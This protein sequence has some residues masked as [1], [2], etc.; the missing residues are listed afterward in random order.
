VLELNPEA[1]AT[2]A[3]IAHRA[4]HKDPA[5]RFRSARQMAQALRLWL[6]EQPP[7][8]DGV[9]NE[10]RRMRWDR[11]A[12]GAVV[13]GGVG[14]V[15]GLFWHGPEQKDLQ[16]AEAAASSP[17]VAAAASAAV[18]PETPASAAVA[19]AAASAVDTVVAA[20]AE[21][22][23]SA[24]SAVAKPAKAVA[25]KP[26]AEPKPITVA[27]APLANGVLQLAI[28]PWGNVEVDGAPAGITPPLNRLSLPEGAHTVTVRNADFPPFTTTVKITADQ[29]VTLR[30]RFGS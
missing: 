29:P 10:R 14:L 20:A 3:A 11:V 28:A 8:T 5:E 16:A 27:A 24:A 13:V 21:P 23:A 4:L 7:G 2:L 17:V 22:V 6:A 12:L 9:A 1:P 19:A 18:L 26:K 25:R 15:A 30:Y